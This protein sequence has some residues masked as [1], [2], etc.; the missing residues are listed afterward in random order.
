MKDL[1]EQFT[2][3]LDKYAIVADV[4]STEPVRPGIG[5]ARIQ[6][7]R[8]TSAQGY[9][10]LIGPAIRFTDADAVGADAVPRMVFTTF[11]APRTATAFRRAGV[12]YLDTAGNGWIEFGDVLMDVQGRPRP[13]R[14]VAPP[15]SAASNL[16][17]TGRAQV[18]FALLAWPW[19]WDASRRELAHAARVS[20]GQAHN[21]L[22]LLSEAGY[23]RY[24]TRTGQTHL[25][26]LWTAEFPIGLAKRLTLAT[27]V[28]QIDRLQKVNATDPVFL[29]G[30]SAAG[31]LLRP[32]TL[33]IY[34]DELDPRL[35]VVNRWR[36]DGVPNVFIRR[37]FWNAPD[38]SD[39]PLTGLRNA[40]WPLVYADLLS[41]DDPRVRG[42]ASD[43]R[44]RHAGPD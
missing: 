29:S 43:L 15:R 30:E 14:A 27:Y 24:P 44:K 25:L 9:A 2:A 40:P 7:T 12:Q 3:G 33:T 6:L 1:I 26:D 38:N 32:A 31:D 36:A 8:G 11:V 22:T 18:V 39:V 4:G 20:V 19:L 35:P 28:G 41:S 5:R 34:V 17:S 10:L 23:A 21:T 37:K 16:F 13:D 42:V